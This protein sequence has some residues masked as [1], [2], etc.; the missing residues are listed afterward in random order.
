M[1]GAVLIGGD[2]NARSTL[3]HDR[4]SDS[5]GDTVVEMISRRGLSVLNEPGFPPTFRNR[6]SADLDVTLVTPLASRRVSDWKVSHDLTSS[7]QFSRFQVIYHHL[8]IF[9]F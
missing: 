8:Y 3:W 1:R 2:V 5:R 6:G 9:I 4:I 7:D